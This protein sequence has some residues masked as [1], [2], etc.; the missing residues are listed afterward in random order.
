MPSTEMLPGS[1]I[2]PTS[3]SMSLDQRLS[4]LFLPDKRLGYPVAGCGGADGRCDADTG[5]LRLAWRNDVERAALAAT[6]FAG[7]A[8]RH[9]RRAGCGPG[10]RVVLG[11]RD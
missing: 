5:S 8:C 9:R 3:L 2:G 6:A 4:H 7:A 1:L 10:A 11:R